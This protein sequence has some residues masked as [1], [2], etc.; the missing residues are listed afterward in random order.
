MEQSPAKDFPNC[1]PVIASGLAPGIDSC[2][3]KAALRSDTGAAI[4][5]FGCC[6]DVVYPKEN[7]KIFEQI[8]QRG[9]IITEFP[10]GTF[11]APRNFS[12]RNR[13]VAGMSLGVSV[14]EGAQCAPAR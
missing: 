9:A 3:Y 6:I 1:G 12:I 7:K 8:T 13:I 5:V 11:P 2:A 4:G 10:V 14:V